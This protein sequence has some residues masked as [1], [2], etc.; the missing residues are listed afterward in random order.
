MIGHKF[1]ESSEDIYVPGQQ[2]AL[3]GAEGDEGHEGEE[4]ALV[5]WLKLAEGL[6][7]SYI[8]NPAEIL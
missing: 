8:R 6:Q 2:I 1:W 7:K 4:V 3:G 5:R